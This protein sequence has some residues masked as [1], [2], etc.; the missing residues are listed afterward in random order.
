MF[1]AERDAQRAR[2]CLARL[3][4][5]R[6]E[7][8]PLVRELLK[9]ND[10][11]SLKLSAQLLAARWGVAEIEPAFIRARFTSAAEPEA[12]RLQALDAL[13]AFRD[14]GLSAELPAVISSNSPRFV[15]RVFAA[16]GRMDDPKL[17]D[18]LLAEYPKLVPELQPL[19][20]DLIMQRERWARKLLDAVLANRVSKS[21]FNANHLRKILESNDRE[22]LWA[23]EKAFGKIRAERNPE[24]E[25]VVAEMNAYFRE[26][27]GDPH[28]GQTVFRNLCAQCHTMYGEG[29]NVGPDITANGRASFEQLISNVFDPSLVIGPAYQVT[30]VVTKDGR[31]LTGL[32]VED[33]EHRIVVRMPGEGKK[34]WPATTSSTPASASFL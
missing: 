8:I 12:T 4:E 7:L 32:I 28:R 23:V 6:D 33:N 24:R 25:K 16:L 2:D 26:N 18:I 21:V 13:I 17:V 31:N 30:T 15:A 29:G 22:A 19:A 14:S 5:R 11:P 34:L 27:I 3:G 20:I 9:R 10:D 1:V